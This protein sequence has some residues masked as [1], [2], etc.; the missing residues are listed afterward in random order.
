MNDV[1]NIVTSIKAL[2]QRMSVS[3]HNVANV[4]STGYKARRAIQSEGP[5][6]RVTM[7]NAGTDLVNEALI[8][9]RIVIDYKAA[10]SAL[11][12]YKEMQKDT[13]DELSGS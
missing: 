4:N 2:D 12:T 10:L 8:Q 7:T 5:S 9:N 3:A 13:L 6:V 1:N 11:R